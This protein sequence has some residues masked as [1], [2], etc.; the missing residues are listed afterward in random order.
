[1]KI[2]LAL[3]YCFYALVLTL[4]R[5]GVRIWPRLDCEQADAMLHVALIVAALGLGTATGF[6]A[7]MSYDPA[8]DMEWVRSAVQG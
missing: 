6:D 4:K 8:P 1:M 5:F 7:L 3:A 2:L